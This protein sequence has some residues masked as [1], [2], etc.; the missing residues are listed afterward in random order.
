MILQQA[1][2]QAQAQKWERDWDKFCKLDRK[3][4]KI[5]KYRVNFSRQIGSWGVMKTVVK[6]DIDRVD[7]D[8][9]DWEQSH[10]AVVDVEGTFH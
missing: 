1:Q 10:S 4:K 8:R 3:Q 5:V 7:I 2:A 9:V 6:I